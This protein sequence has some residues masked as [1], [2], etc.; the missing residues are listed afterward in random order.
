MHLHYQTPPYAAGTC[1][2]CG[3]VGPSTEWPRGAQHRVTARCVGPKKS[4]LSAW[5]LG[6]WYPDR[7]FTVCPGNLWTPDHQTRILALGIP[8]KR[9]RGFQVRR[10]SSAATGCTFPGSAAALS[11]GSAADC[12][13]RRPTD[14]KTADTH[15]HIRIRVWWSGLWTV[16]ATLL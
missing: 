11:C 15:V 1:L 2:C 10:A 3:C 12:S 13:R 9:N 6:T 14:L 4:T 5:G 16:V 8:K 7:F